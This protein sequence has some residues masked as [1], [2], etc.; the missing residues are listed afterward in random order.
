MPILIAAHI[1]LRN[2]ERKEKKNAPFLR[3]IKQ[4][5]VKSVRQ[6][7]AVKE[8]GT[9]KVPTAPI[10]EDGLENREE[11]RPCLQQGAYSQKWQDEVASQGTYKGLG[12]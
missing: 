5:V 8:R 1:R 2:P 4:S 7:S 3:A 10:H 9:S 11:N 6:R 12:N